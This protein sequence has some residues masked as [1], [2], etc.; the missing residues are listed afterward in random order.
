MELNEVILVK[1]RKNSKFPMKCELLSNH[2][3]KSSEKDG[4]KEEV[5]LREKPANNKRN[6]TTSMYVDSLT[7]TNS[8]KSVA[9]CNSN[10]PSSEQSDKP[11]LTQSNLKKSVKNSLEQ[12]DKPPLLSQSTNI[13]VS[14]KKKSTDDNDDDYLPSE[15]DSEETEEDDQ[16]T[17]NS[18]ENEPRKKQI[19]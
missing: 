18:K 16:S 7:Q 19:I 14:G 9:A 2:L 8:K 6:A 12:P 17:G 4:D 1:M 15:C 5:R 13:I 10:K 11:P 3:I